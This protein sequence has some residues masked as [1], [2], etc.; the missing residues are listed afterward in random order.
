M[1]WRAFDTEAE[2]SEV[3][4]AAHLINE[5]C[6]ISIPFGGYRYDLIADKEGEIVRVQTKKARQIS[7]HKYGIPVGSYNSSEVDIFAG[8]ITE[9]EMTFY[10]AINK[11]GKNDFRINTKSREE[12]IPENRPHAKLLEDY[13]FEQA[14]SDWRDEQ[15]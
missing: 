9:M 1:N 12:I 10:V 6:Q 7:E 13:T 8:Y 4:V 15:N 14:L 11:V 5:G 3:R 2:R